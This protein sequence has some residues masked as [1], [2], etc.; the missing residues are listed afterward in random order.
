MLPTDWVKVRTYRH[1]NLLLIASK[2]PSSVAAKRCIC[3]TCSFSNRPKPLFTRFS[4]VYLSHDEKFLEDY[5]I[6]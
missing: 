6:S 5:I 2:L 4:D 3:E 1:G